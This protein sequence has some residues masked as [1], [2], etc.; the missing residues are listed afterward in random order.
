MVFTMTQKTTINSNV[1][2]RNNVPSACVI[3]TRACSE[4]LSTYAL[5]T[6]LIAEE[7]LDFD[8]HAGNVRSLAQAIRPGNIVKG[9][10]FSNDDSLVRIAIKRGATLIVTN[11]V[12][13]ALLAAAHAAQDVGKP[14]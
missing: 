3:T 14:E 12:L 8:D 7:T 2:G 6:T 13:S 1:A 11:P 10:I 5:P 9:R 4:F